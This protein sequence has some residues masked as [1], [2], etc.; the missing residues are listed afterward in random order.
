LVLI[1]SDEKDPFNRKPL[2]IKDLVP[3]TELKEK[4]NQWLKENGCN[5]DDS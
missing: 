3:A 1:F 4:I 5:P 2:T